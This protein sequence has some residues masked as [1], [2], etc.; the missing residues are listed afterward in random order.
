VR[1]AEGGHI[2]KNVHWV[3]ATTVCLLVTTSNAETAKVHLRCTGQTAISGKAAEH[4]VTVFDTKAEVDGLPY[5]AGISETQYAL[6]APNP[7]TAIIPEEPK[8]IL[9]RIDRIT[10]H[11][12]ISAGISQRESGRCVKMRRHL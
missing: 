4:V 1:P 3:L 5:S 12:E 10:G 8:M 7:V 2:G 9:L 11:Y 6:L